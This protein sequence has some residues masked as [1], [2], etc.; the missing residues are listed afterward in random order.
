MEKMAR[1]FLCSHC[2]SEIKSE[3]TVERVTWGRAKE[4]KKE[5]RFISVNFRKMDLD[6]RYYN[7]DFC[8]KEIRPGDRS[9]AWTIGKIPI[10]ENDYL[11][12]DWD[13]KKANA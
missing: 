6:P 13:E 11:E 7:C 9:C 2:A 3:S 8:N 10:W 4:P 1:Y 5:Q 12:G